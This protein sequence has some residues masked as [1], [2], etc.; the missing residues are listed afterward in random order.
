MSTARRRVLFVLPWIAVTGVVVFLARQPADT[1][2]IR[3]A[4]YRPA[5]AVFYLDRWTALGGA[6]DHTHDANEMIAFGVPGDVG[7]ACPQDV[8]EEPLGFRVYAGGHWFLSGPS[9]RPAKGDIVLGKPGDVPFCADFDGDGIADS[10]VFRG[11]EW[12]V[13]TKRAGSDVEI[14]F[15]LGTAGDRPV[16]LNVK[17]AGNKT[18]RR[19]LVYGVYRRGV[20]YIDAKGT[21]KVE[22][23]HTLGGLPQDV[24]LL[25]PRWSAAA[26]TTPPYSLAIFRDG[27]WFVKPDPD[28]T[29][30]LSFGFGA[31]GDLPGFV[32]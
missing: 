31:A 5:N 13:A 4:L 12:F 27:T 17:G 30:T 25:I 20:W 9:N 22:A 15:S 19:N 2:S 21:G 32:R 29:Q 11:G 24:P 10:G 23:E 8:R 3:F 1:R 6:L 18:D 16:A 26:G 14:R 28:G 7:L